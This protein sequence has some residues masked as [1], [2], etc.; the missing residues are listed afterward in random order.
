MTVIHATFM[1]IRD[2]RRTVEELAQMGVTAVDVQRLADVD[3]P[4]ADPVLVTVAV[5]DGHARRA[6]RPPQRR[7]RRGGRGGLTPARA[8]TQPARAGC[9][10]SVR[11]VASP[12]DRD[13]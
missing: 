3:P 9:L 10:T 7:R 12:R 2:V 13:V 5:D 8:G 4:L 6:R 1:D 11:L